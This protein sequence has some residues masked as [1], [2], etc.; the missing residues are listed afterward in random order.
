MKEYIDSFLRT[1][2]PG[3]FYNLKYYRVAQK[4]GNKLNERDKRFKELIER[5]KDKKCLQIGVRD[6]KYA[7]YWISVDL[8]DTSEEIDF[9]YDIHKLKF[10]DGT[11]DIVVCNAILEHV[12]N[13]LKAI[14]ELHRVLREGGEIWV[15]VPFNQP[16]HP[17]PNDY[18]RV[19]LPG[20]RI[21]MSKFNETSS[22]FFLINNSSIYNGI[23]FHGRK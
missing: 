12:E 17:A 13:P 21:W 11:F 7:P 16:Y 8:Y 15:E 3:F 18:W 23:Y 22:G 1:Y 2:F 10:D 19:T 9:N 20:L 6:R 14:E 5:S 4:L